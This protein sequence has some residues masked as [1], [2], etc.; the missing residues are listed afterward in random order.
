MISTGRRH[1]LS[2]AP[3]SEARYVSRQLEREGL[4]SKEKQ[5][6][7]QNKRMDRRT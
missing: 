6:V 4:H 5:M 7:A 3:H 2:T 1:Q